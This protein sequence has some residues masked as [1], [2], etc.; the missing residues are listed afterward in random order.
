MTT[1][2]DESPGGSRLLWALRYHARL[3]VVAALLVLAL[4]AAAVGRLLLLPA[5]HTATAAV[6]ATDLEFSAE[7]VP[8]L[9][10]AIYQQDGVLTDALRRGQLPWTVDQLRDEHSDVVPLEDNVLIN[11]VGRAQD[12]ALAV[13]AANSLA[14]ALADALR[15]SGTEAT[16]TVQASALRAVQDSRLV[17]LAVTVLGGLVA[18]VAVVLGLAALLLALRR[19]VTRPGE[20]RR[21]TGAE[22]LS[23]VHLP[24]RGRTVEPLP[25]LAALQLEL[26]RRAADVV[27]M[28]TTAGADAVRSAVAVSYAHAV[29]LSHDVTLVGST[30]AVD[31]VLNLPDDSR[32]LEHDRV[33]PLPA[34]SGR[35]VVD[36]FDDE[37]AA[38]R[39]PLPP[40]G[41]VVLVLPEGA[42]RDKVLAVLDRCRPQD[43]AGLVFVSRL[44]RRGRHR[45][46]PAGP[47]RWTRSETEA[48]APPADPAPV[49]AGAAGTVGTSHVGG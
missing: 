10:A 37:L 28:T 9:A 17:P 15:R 2:H 25:G 3:L 11:V 48:Y 24:R 12:P 40:R 41:V 18:A 47:A 4:T 38:F 39:E 46:L 16:F 8:R 31:L 19:P 20:A 33:L 27:L 44:G 29:G 14:D 35:T 1:P 6:I 32:V 13:R 5:E 43:L 30:T 36:G 21:L 22:I 45:G 26:D 34:E 7:R 42:A 23:V 49:P